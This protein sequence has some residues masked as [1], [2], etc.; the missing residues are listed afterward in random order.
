MERG[1]KYHFKRAIIGQPAKHHLNGVLLA[2]WWWPNIEYWLPSFVVLQGI[3]TSIAKKP[4]IF[5]IPP[6][7]LDP[8]MIIL[9]YFWPLL[10]S[11]LSLRS[12]EWP[13]YTGFIVQN[14]YITLCVLMDSSIWL[15]TINLG[16]LIVFI[17]GS[18]D[19]DIFQ[20]LKVVLSLSKQCRPWWNAAYC[21]ISSGS[22]L[23][24]S[25][26]SQG[27]SKYQVTDFQHDF[28]C[29]HP[30]SPSQQFFSHA[31]MGLLGLNCASTKQRIRLM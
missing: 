27:S 30:L 6:P 8:H 7:P 23:S 11:H 22:S 1:S 24:K 9:Q 28:I 16:W 18:W 25:E 2:G 5:V 29:F 19:D 31:G 14:Y 17:K 21:S 4:Y 3:R 10:S 26:S 12:F 20:S 15:D 13:F